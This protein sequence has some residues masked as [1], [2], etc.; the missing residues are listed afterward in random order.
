MKF[1]KDL[2][3][4]SVELFQAT[5]AAALIGGPLFVYMIYFWKP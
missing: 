1:L 2:K 5:V 4:L 3:A